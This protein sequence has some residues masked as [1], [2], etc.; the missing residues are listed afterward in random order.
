MV[1]CCDQIGNLTRVII[2]GFA[3]LGVSCQLSVLESHDFISL[4]PLFPHHGF[5]TQ[6]ALQ[7]LA[8]TNCE[9]MKYESDEYTDGKI[10]L[11]VDNDD[12]EKCPSNMGTEELDE[13]PFMRAARAMMTLSILA[14]FGG[15]C[16]V[17][18][19]FLCC[20]ICCA[21]ILESLAFQAA[22]LLG[23]LAY[24]SFG[25]E[26]CTGE[27][28]DTLQAAVEDVAFGSQDIGD[29][30]NCSFGKG[31][32]LNVGAMVIYFAVSVALCFTPKPTP[33]LSQFTK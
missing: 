5:T 6:I 18:F 29:L 10:G 14:A 1:C 7:V 8:S 2:L 12:I 32:S 28:E 13:D 22:T 20:R 33:V 24:L 11:F 23:G 25:S 17:S 4:C 26:Y 15:A 9:F 27:P 30:Y 21:A 16:L 19:E 31:C 3:G